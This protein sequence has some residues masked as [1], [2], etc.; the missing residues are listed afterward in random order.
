MQVMFLGTR[1]SSASRI[2]VSLTGSYLSS[3][4]VRRGSGRRGVCLLVCVVRAPV[5]RDLE[6]VVSKDLAGRE[7]AV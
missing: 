1:P 7:I 3:L 5:R 6:N 4:E 2:R